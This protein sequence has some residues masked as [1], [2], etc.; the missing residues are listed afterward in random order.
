MPAGCFHVSFGAAEVARGFEGASQALT[1]LECSISYL[2]RGS[3]LDGSDRGRMLG[4]LDAEL[5]QICAPPNAAILDYTQSPPGPLN[6]R[7]FWLR[8][9]FEA[10]EDADGV[11]RRTATLKLFI[12][13]VNA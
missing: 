12:P 9:R 8:P 6:R 2:T 4:V 10:A 3:S 1:A 5:L 11:I 13:E 7:V